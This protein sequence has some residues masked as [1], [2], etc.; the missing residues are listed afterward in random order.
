M[1]IW[2]V[3][4]EW[5]ATFFF[6]MSARHLSI[7]GEKVDR[8]GGICNPGFLFFFFGFFSSPIHAGQRRRRSAAARTRGKDGPKALAGAAARA[9]P[10]SSRPNC[11]RKSD[12]GGTRKT[13]SRGNSGGV[14]MMAGANG[15]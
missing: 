4:Q 12:Q 9:Y 1:G 15:A 3:Q 10:A 5:E 11:N 8:K 2:I 13:P 6:F 14:W 7:C